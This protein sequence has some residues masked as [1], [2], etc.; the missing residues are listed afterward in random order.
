LFLR[1]RSWTVRGILRS[2]E[3]VTDTPIDFSREAVDDFIIELTRNLTSLSGMVRDARGAPIDGS[4]V[5]IFA[6]DS[7]RWAPPSRFIR[8]VHPDRDGGGA[9]QTRG[10][11]PG[12]YLAV[13]VERLESGLATNPSVLERLRRSGAAVRVSLREGESSSVELRLLETF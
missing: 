1:A 11:P 4:V 2:G 13:A 12:T 9:F 8:T 3:D 7:D 6:E 10:L 5:V